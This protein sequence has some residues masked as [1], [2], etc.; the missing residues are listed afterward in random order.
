MNINKLIKGK[1]LLLVDDE[2]DVLDSLIEQL[3]LC[4]IDTASSFEEGKKML[5]EQSYDLVV[6]DIMGVR[7][8]ELLSIANN[9]KIPALM[10]TAHALT[11][12]SLDKSFKGGAAYF[13]P[14]E[15]MVDIEFFIAD[16]FEAIEEK[17]NPWERLLD[18]LGGFY[19]RRFQGQGWREK[20]DEFLKKKINKFV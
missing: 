2:P 19:D 5:E 15:K 17:K 13:A 4:K 1:K 8:F 10:L 18:R 14:K 7:G 3:S 6:L 9:Q 11:E 12:E 20:E 16:I